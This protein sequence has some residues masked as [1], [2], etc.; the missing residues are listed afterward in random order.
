[1]PLKVNVGGSW[2]Q[3]RLSVKVS[4]QWREAPQVYVKVSGAWKPLYSFTWEKGAWGACSA[5]CGGGTQTRTVRAKRSDGQYFSDAVGT[6]FAGEKPAT[7][8]ACNT[9]DCVVSG[10]FYEEG[11]T[12]IYWLTKNWGT[13]D[14]P[15]YLTEVIFYEDG[16]IIYQ[17]F[18][19]TGQ[20]TGWTVELNGCTYSFG[21]CVSCP[22]ST[23]E[24][25]LYKL[26]KSC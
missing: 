17:T 23:R 16:E 7:S 6:R 10:C 2:K 19:S 20:G 4:G 15:A 9:H 26:C 1:M 18:L 5:E 21:D 24:P 12:Y 11:R 8:Q 3:T 14:Y 13:S 25:H 22:E